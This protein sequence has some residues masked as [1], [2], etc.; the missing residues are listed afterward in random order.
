MTLS[1]IAKDHVSGDI[2]VCGYTDI[3]CF[4]SLVPHVSLKGGVATQ[5][6]VNVDNGLKFLE[7]LENGHDAI[8]SGNSVINEDPNSNMRQ[9]IAIDSKGNTFEHTGDDCLNYKNSLAGENFVIAGNCLYSSEVI[10]N[11]AK[12]FKKS[13]FES[14]PLR[15]IKAIQE[16]ERSGGHARVIEYND[17]KTKQI[18]ERPTTEVF[19]NIMSAALIIA[20]RKPELCHNL[21]VDA[22]E[23]AI[24]DLEHTYI[25]TRDSAEKLDRFYN[26]SIVVKPFFWRRISS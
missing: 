23:N 26:G 19:G 12:H 14:F 2:G 22:S 15:L 3:P 17:P 10:E 11:T 20:S 7:S 8:Y 25:N 6:Y 5:A 24:F 16:G 1:I 4:G 21:R 18:I 13:T 9:M